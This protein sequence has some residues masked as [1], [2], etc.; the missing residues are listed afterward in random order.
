MHLD[1]CHYVRD[2]FSEYVES[3]KIVMAMLNDVLSTV[4]DH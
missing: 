1:A 3:L 2:K 4:I